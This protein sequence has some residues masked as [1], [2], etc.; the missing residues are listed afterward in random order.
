MDRWE[1]RIDWVAVMA[2][3]WKVLQPVIIAMLVALLLQLGWT[4]PNGEEP[5][6]QAAGISHFSNVTTTGDVVVGDDLSVTDDAAVTGLVTVGE[7][8]GVTG[9]TTLSGALSS[10]AATLASLSVTAG[11]TIG[12]WGRYTEQTPIS[13]TMNMTITAAGTYQPLT[14]AGNVNTSALAAGSVGQVLVLTNESNTTITITD[15]GTVMLSAN[16]AGSQYDTLTLLADGTNW[17]EVA[18]STN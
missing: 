7:T 4:P 10:G 1:K 8:L 17:L 5:L 13:V 3:A 15:T 12:T 16:W 11:G 18:R 14:S 2:V 6:L 9:D